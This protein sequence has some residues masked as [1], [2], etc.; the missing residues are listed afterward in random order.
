MV[1][2]MRRRWSRVFFYSAVVVVGSLTAVGT[3]LLYLTETAPSVADAPQ[4]VSAVLAAHSAPSDN[5]AIPARVAT[6]VLATEDSRYYHDPALDP[7]G[8]LRA[9]VGLLTS[10]G[11]DGG[12]SIEQQLAKLLYAPGTAVGAE[13]RQVGVAFRLDQHFSKAQILAM[14]LNVAYFG[15]GAYGVTAASYHYFGVMPGQLS[16]AQASLIAGLVQAPTEYDPHGH[17]GLARERQAHVLSRL[18]AT[19]ALTRAEAAAV[20]GEPLDPAISFFG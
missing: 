6:A 1:Q 18:V 5:G 20:F 11:N 2:R 9:A 16:W 3:A 19:H 12:A 10:N 14:Y 7:L 4:R 8:V 17:L 13:I 15:D